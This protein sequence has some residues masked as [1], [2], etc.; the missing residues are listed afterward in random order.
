MLIHPAGLYL[1]RNGRRVGIRADRGERQRW[2]W[3]TTLGYY[4]QADGRA[5]ARR[6]GESRLDLVREVP[7]C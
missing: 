7:A 6:G 2:R 3:I 4:V 5:T 1:T